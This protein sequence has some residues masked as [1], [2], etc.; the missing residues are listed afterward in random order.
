MSFLPPPQQPSTP[1]NSESPLTANTSKHGLLSVAAAPTYNKHEPLVVHSETNIED[2]EETFRSL[3]APPTI[4]D[5]EK[6]QEPPTYY[7]DSLLTS[8]FKFTTHLDQCNN[9]LAKLVNMMNSNNLLDST[10]PPPPPP[11]PQLCD[12]S[13]ENYPH[14]D[15]TQV[16]N[17]VTYNEFMVA[18]PNNEEDNQNEVPLHRMKTS[19]AFFGLT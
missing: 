2:N 6:Q 13:I 15:E 7:D 14:L 4:A 12:M 8:R 16:Y 11:P 10:L 3:L 17:D 18:N 1:T 19:K 5:K 9:S